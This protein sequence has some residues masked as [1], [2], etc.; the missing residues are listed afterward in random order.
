[1]HFF[2]V[3][4]YVRFMR[5]DLFRGRH[6]VMLAF[7]TYDPAENCGVIQLYVYVHAGA[8]GFLGARLQQSC[9]PRNFGVICGDHSRERRLVDENLNRQLWRGSLCISYGSWRHALV[10]GKL[11]GPLAKVT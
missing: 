3:K 11:F 1:M 5:I 8:L 4:S 2:G 9:K 6:L 7:G 10:A